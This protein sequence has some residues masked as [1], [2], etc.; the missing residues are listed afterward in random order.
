MEGPTDNFQEL[1]EAQITQGSLWHQDRQL[2]DPCNSIDITGPDATTNNVHVSLTLPTPGAFTGSLCQKHLGGQGMAYSMAPGSWRNALVHFQ[3]SSSIYLCLLTLPLN[4][5][6]KFSSS[7]W[8]SCPTTLRCAF[9]LFEELVT[10]I[11]I[12]TRLGTM[13]IGHSLAVSHLF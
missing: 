10:C 2:K 4:I 13:E 3:Y 6:N 9:H 7:C 5:I 8:K 11:H 1:L 12:C